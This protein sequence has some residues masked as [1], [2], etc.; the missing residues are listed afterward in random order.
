MGTKF[1][2]V[3]K[4]NENKIKTK[5]NSMNYFFKKSYPKEHG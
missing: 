3:K 4:M 5:Y 2:K 1:D